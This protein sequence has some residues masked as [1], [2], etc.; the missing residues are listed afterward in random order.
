LNDSIVSRSAG[1]SRRA[2]AFFATLVRMLAIPCAAALAL[3]GCSGGDA[4]EPRE[5]RNVLLISL[6]TLRADH[7]GVYGFERDSTPNLDALAR[8]ALRNLQ[9]AGAVSDGA[10]RY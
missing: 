7:M 1:P 5:I 2:S 4:P 8:E 3:A 10:P 9:G 6:D